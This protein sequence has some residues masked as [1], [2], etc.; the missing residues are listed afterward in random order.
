[1]TDEDDLERMLLLIRDADKLIALHQ[2]TIDRLILLEQS[3]VLADR[4]MAKMRAGRDA[5]QRHLQEIL[6]QLDYSRQSDDRT[7][8]ER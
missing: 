8:Q 6:A 4:L 7:Q 1:M 3:T 2:R 5:R